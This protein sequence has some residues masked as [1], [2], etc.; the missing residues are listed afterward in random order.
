MTHAYATT[1]SAG[2][3]DKVGVI[4]TAAIAGSFTLDRYNYLQ[5]SQPTGA[6]TITDAAALYFN[7]AAGT[8]KATLAATTKATPG[9]VDAWVKI[10]INGTLYYMPAYL[11]STA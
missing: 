3:A 4:K 10:N 8:H 2:A 11:S 1:L 5:L 9:A 6:A 7:A